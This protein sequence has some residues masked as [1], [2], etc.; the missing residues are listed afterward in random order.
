[1]SHQT[2]QQE[3]N[4]LKAVANTVDSLLV[5]ER[6]MQ[7]ELSGKLRQLEDENREL[8]AEL[9]FYE[10]L[11]PMSE[12]GAVAVR[13]L[14]LE[15]SQPDL[16][17]WRLLLMQPERRPSTFEGELELLFNG[18]LGG[19]AWQQ[20]SARQP[21]RVERQARLQG[22][23]ALPA[24]AVLQSVTVRLWQAGEIKATHTQRMP[25]P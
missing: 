15:R 25:R 21:I 6:A 17:Q 11:I 12:S 3:R 24:S 7:A 5:A 2:L 22:Q 8:K 23:L 16:V 4:E 10:D 13:G 20:A 14:R 1:M 19:K 18:E 9:Q